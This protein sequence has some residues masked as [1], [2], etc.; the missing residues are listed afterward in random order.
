MGTNSKL[1]MQFRGRPERLAGW[2]GALT[3]DAPAFLETWET[4][5]TQ[6]GRSS[7]ITLFAGGAAGEGAGYRTRG[8]HAPAPAPLVR[9]ALAALERVVPGSAAGFNGRAWLDD[10]AA[11]PW[12]HGSY[13]AFL[14]GQLT[15]FSG[16][17][18]RP[19]RG[20]HFAGE[21]TSLE[22]QGYLEGAIESGERCA[23]EIL[24]A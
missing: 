22:Y 13:A 15:R 9:D 21:Q 5:L 17:L 23:L 6:P 2:D 19:E 24:R 12:A 8:A 7:L 10:W 14:P 18:G 1:L 3:T 20:L 16:S 11:D 4:S